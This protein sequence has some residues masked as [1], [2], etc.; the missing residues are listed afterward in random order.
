M[1]EVDQF[2]DVI[3]RDY[4]EYN[5]INQSKQN[6]GNIDIDYLNEYNSAIENTD[7]TLEY[8]DFFNWLGVN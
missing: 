4:N 3:I 8:N 7:N 1:Q 5:N 2:L 6:L